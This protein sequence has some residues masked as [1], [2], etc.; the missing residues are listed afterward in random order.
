MSRSKLI[1][2]INH[3]KIEVDILKARKADSKIIEMLESRLKEY[4]EELKGAG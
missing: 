4:K 3:L 1:N 2:H